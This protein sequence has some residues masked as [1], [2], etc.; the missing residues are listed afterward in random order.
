MQIETDFQSDE[1]Y[2]T[3][4]K[5]F[6]KLLKSEQLKF[7]S[8]REK[9]LETLYNSDTHISSEE[10]FLLLKS[11]DENIG[12][13]TIYRTLSLLEREKIVTSLYTE[14]VKKY[15]LSHKKHHDHLICSVC[16]KIIEFVS[17]EIEELQ[18]EVA[19]NF[20]FK[21]LDHNMQIF[22]ICKECQNKGKN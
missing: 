5:R 3:L 4:L 7:T 17:Q 21:I 18:D 20:G 9:V 13:A 10:L 19:E 12:I 2:Q 16:G 8:Q 11:R 15:E 1:E 22:G 14:N 6:K